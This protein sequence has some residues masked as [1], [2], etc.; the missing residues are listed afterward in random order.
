ME[1]KLP[2]MFGW[3][4]YPDYQYYLWLDG[5]IQLAKPE[6]LACFV[7]QI[8][9]S[10]IVVIRHHRR[11]NIRQEVRYL[12]KGMREESIYLVS[13]YVGEQHKELY[14][15][16]ENDKDYVDDLLVI[17]GVFMYR[18]TPAVQEMMKQWWY[19]NTRYCLQDQLSFAYVLKKSGIR[20]KVL[21]H[22]Y[23]KWDLIK[24]TQHTKRN[25]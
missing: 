17:G 5:N 15:L 16:I 20:I 7:D 10:D 14:R 19:Y 23:T 24:P 8:K 4:L 22:D 9:D 18:N 6:T 12:R 25:V 21:D 1:A 11:P 3:Q 2:K 13:R